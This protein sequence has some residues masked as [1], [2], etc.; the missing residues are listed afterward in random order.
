MR[1]PTQPNSID[2]MGQ[3]LPPTPRKG[4]SFWAA[5][6]LLVAMIAVALVFIVTKKNSFEQPT[7]RSAA[8][9]LDLLDKNSDM[10]TTSAHVQAL[11]LSSLDAQS[12]A[13]TTSRED[14]LKELEA[15]NQ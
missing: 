3:S 5:I 4:R 11:Q 14:R 10:V 9:E 8:E 2:T 7:D 15:L 13:V 12:Q 1:V 6:G